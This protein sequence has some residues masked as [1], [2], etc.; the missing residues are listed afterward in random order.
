MD[1]RLQDYCLD[2][3]TLL[4]LRADPLSFTY[5]FLLECASENSQSQQDHDEAI[6]WVGL[7]QHI[8]REYIRLRRLAKKS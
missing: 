1:K 6:A 3:H 2:I 8:V 7:N 5:Q 4:R